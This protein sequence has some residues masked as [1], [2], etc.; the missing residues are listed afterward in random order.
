MSWQS[1]IEEILRRRKFAQ[2]LGGAEAVS[3]QHK[4]GKKT[5]R[6]R[7]DALCDPGSF[8]EIGVLTGAAKYD[9]DGKLKSVTPANSVIG[10]GRVSGQRIVISADDFTIRG[11]SSE[12]AVSEK[13]I[14]AERLA[15][16]L[17]VPLV[18]LVE[19]AGG[20]VRLLEK[21]GATKLPG[22]SDWPFASMLGQIPVIGVALGACAGLGAVKVASSHLSVMVKE[23][24][25][26]FTAGPPVVEAGLKETIT[27]EE[28]GGYQV[29]AHGSGI[30]DNE[31]DDEDDAL[32]QV[33]TFLSYLP[34]NVHRPPVPQP[35]DDDPE[36]REE[37]LLSV[38][39]RERR[40]VYKARKILEMVLDRDSIF[41][42]ARHNG[43]SLITSLARLNGYPVGVLANDPYHYGGA[44]TVESSIKMENFVDFCDT[45]HIPLVSFFDQAGVMIGL[46]A[47]KAGTIRFAM[48]ALAAIEQ[49]STQ[50]C[51]IIVRR[52]FGVAGSAYGRLSGINMR[53]AWPSAVWGSLPIEGGVAA[54]F[55]REIAEHPDPKAKIKELE[56]E[57]NK[58]SS[59]FK[60]AERFGVNDIIDPRDTRSVLC[61]WIGDVYQQIP[62]SLGPRQRT[63][64]R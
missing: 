62:G 50:W 51:S 40:Q 37:A 2:D 11:G 28:L 38:I 27:K 53:Y 16:D 23:T 22:Y 31:A 56:N 35:C 18:R 4:F 63:M 47:E 52:A 41:E 21:Q 33:K 34:S 44:M 45:F 42:L 43:P 55:R 58:F 17:Q 48:R 64:R 1:E 19:T 61:D 12:A 49:S 32:E 25:Q 6:E 30:V 26:V 57:Y 39:P 14:Y 29:H 5:V 54:A 24:S 10:K 20:S 15:L 3:R 60:T 46:E 59:P 7:I 8:R 36:R 9:E 13:W